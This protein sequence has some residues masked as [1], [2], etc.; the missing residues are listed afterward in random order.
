MKYIN[1]KTTSKALMLM[2]GIITSV[3]VIGISDAYA[4]N[5]NGNTW[6]HTGVTFSCSSVSGITK[7]ATVSPCNDLTTSSNVWEIT[8]SNL[9]FTEVTTG[10]D[11]PVYAWTSGVSGA[12]KTVTYL[13]GS[14]ITNAYI[15]MNKNL[16]WEDSAVDT[17]SNGYDWRTATGHEFGHAAGLAHRSATPLTIMESTIAMNEYHRSPSSHDEQHLKD[18]Y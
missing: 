17:S 5:W 6:Y 8:N 11:I 3:S 18:N 9:T 2:V 15:A 4:T 16:S 7:T 1:T 10:A 13:S 14:T 12:G